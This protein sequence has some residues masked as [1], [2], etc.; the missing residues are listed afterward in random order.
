MA[1]KI[2]LIDCGE[3]TQLQLIKYKLSLFKIDAVFISHLHGDHYLGLPG[4]LNTL[5]LYGRKDPLHIYGP[6]GLK[7]L[8]NL[9]FR[10]AQTQP[11][12]EIV[13]H[14]TVSSRPKV[15]Y[16][17]ADLTV[18]MIPLQHRIPCYGYHFTWRMQK[19]H[20]LDAR[21]KKYGLGRDAMIC[22][23]NGED[24][25]EHDTLYPHRQFTRLNKQKLSYTYIS[26][27]L[28]LEEISRHFKHTDI[29]YHEST[30]LDNLLDKAEKHY[31]STSIQAAKMAGICGA[32]KLILGHFSSRYLNT[33]ALLL[34]ARTV[35]ENTECAADGKVFA[36]SK[37]I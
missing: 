18:K 24:F 25:M 22:F 3:G 32:E 34:E 17:H 16:R 1:G 36:I 14:E 13:W 21:C 31:H 33:D 28:Y 29:L 15:I 9:N 23:K 30:Y 27:T 10:F 26:D 2:F 5:A 19:F 12:Y 7:P 37:K 11:G 6:K 20:V 8:I 35:F 4:L